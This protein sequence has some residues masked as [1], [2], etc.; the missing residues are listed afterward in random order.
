[1]KTIY[2]LYDVK[3]PEVIMYVGA[4]NNPD[5]RLFDHKQNNYIVR[6]SKKESW[7]KEI[8]ESGGSI[9]LKVLEVTPEESWRDAE[10][11]W[12]AHYRSI[13]PNLTNRTRGGDG[14][15]GPGKGASCFVEPIKDAKAIKRLKSILRDSPRNYALFVLGINIAFR[16]GDLLRIKVGDVRGKKAGDDLLIK[17]EKTGNLRRVTLNEA[18]IEAI[19]Y[20]LK[21][22]KLLDDDPLFLGERGVLTVHTVSRLVK[23]WCKDVGLKGN[24]GSHSLRKTWGY[25]QRVTFNTELPLLT[26]AFGHATQKQTL[27]YLCIQPEERK[28]LYMNSL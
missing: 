1:M 9:G 11:K 21:N 2:G 22:V 12:I 28:A 10:R 5:A 26:D 13:N 19:E 4:T 25:H 3:E 27:H 14:H 8:N 16:A 15:W 7:V 17:E 23:N 24:Y 6:L 18:S 20:Y